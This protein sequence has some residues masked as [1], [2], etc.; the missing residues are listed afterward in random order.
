MNNYE[1]KVDDKPKE[2]KNFI[3]NH[4][5]TFFTLVTLIIIV[6]IITYFRIKIQM[7]LGPISDSCDFLSNA[8]IFAGQSTG[9]SDLTR[10]PFFSFI[11]SLFFRLGYVYT[12]T[13]FVIDGLMFIFGVVG[14]FLFLKLR[15]NDI[16]SFLGGL[17]YSTFFIVLAVLGFGFSD[18]ASVSIT[19]WTLYFLVLAVNKN[20]KFFY[21]LFPCIMMAFLTRYNMA[22]LLFPITLY[23][24]INKD[25]IKSFKSMFVGILMSMVLIMPFLFFY[26]VKFNNL[27]YPFFFFFNKTTQS[28]SSALASYQPHPLFFIERFPY[29]LGW[30]V[31]LVLLM[32]A[33]GL[34]IYGFIKVRRGHL[35]LFTDFE[36]K[37]WSLK[38]KLIIFVALIIIFVVT[39]SQIFYL[40]SEALFFVLGYLLYDLTKDLK[41][42]DMDL[43]LLVFTLFMS[44]L[45]FNSVY[46][47]KDIR[48]FVTMAPS[49][50]YFLVLGL[51]EISNG[52]KL[53]VKKRNITPPLIALVVS[54]ILILSVVP[55][56]Q[57][58]YQSNY[59]YKVNNNNMDLASEWFINYDPNYKNKIIFS[60]LYPYFGWYLRTNIG[61][62]PKFKDNQALYG[63][64]N[65]YNLTSQDN[66][67]LNNYLV[68]KNVDY[69]LSNMKGL[70]L[71]SYK[72]I[73]QFGNI[74]IYKR[75]NNC[76]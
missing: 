40:Y 69:Y 21:F 56:L 13:I 19:I 70:N 58:I 9:Y 50:S 17:I 55:N 73:K 3:R 1:R 33:L 63:I 20:S 49:V 51:S 61:M 72:L 4:A 11:I 59:D 15:F 31:D 43:H 42:K 62:T 28:F 54:F 67:A 22:L 53:T 68:S 57:I 44:F 23:I 35:K 45:I 8:L 41:I 7:D 18:L 12:S 39:F 64:V 76:N 25:E 24:L 14:L 2:Q 34:F 30:G 26:Y 27:F 47:I 74:T 46:V 37:M 38:F 32:T 36:I 52:L 29:L 16:E 66:M 65:D 48:Y 71:T 6:S 10:P 75:Y 5:S 60:E